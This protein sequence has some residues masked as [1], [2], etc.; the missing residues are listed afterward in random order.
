MAARAIALLN[1]LVVKVSLSATCEFEHG[2]AKVGC[3]PNQPFVHHAANGGGEPNPTVLII[4][5]PG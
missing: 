2:A 3:F 4:A 5:Q 1:Q